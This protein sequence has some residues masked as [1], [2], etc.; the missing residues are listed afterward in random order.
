M[1][2]KKYEGCPFC[3]YARMKKDICG[4]YCVGEHFKEP[5]GTC[6]HFINYRDNKAIRAIRGKRTS[7][8][9]DK[10]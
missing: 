4:I 3:Y 9:V 2:S 8:E 1:G 5:D 7:V 10:P 6:R